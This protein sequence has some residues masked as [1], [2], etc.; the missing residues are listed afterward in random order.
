VRSGARDRYCEI[1]LNLR[2]GHLLRREIV[3]NR[4]VVNKLAEKGR[5]FSYIG[6]DDVPDGAGDLLA[7]GVSPAVRERSKAGTSG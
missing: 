6:I 7:P 2:C 3:H 1:A 4:Y 5:N